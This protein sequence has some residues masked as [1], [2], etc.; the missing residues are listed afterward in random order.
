MCACSDASVVYDSETY[1]LKSTM[2]LSPWDSPSKSTGVGCHVLLQGIFPTLG[3]NLGFLCSIFFTTEPPGKPGDSGTMMLFAKIE[4]TGKG[5]S[6][7]RG[8]RW[9]GDEF[10]FGYVEFQVPIGHPS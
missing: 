4:N 5:V 2:L 1:G 8:L 10:C 7:N 3:W 6:F 9:G